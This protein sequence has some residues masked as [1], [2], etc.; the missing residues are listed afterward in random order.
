MKKRYYKDIDRSTF[1]FIYGDSPIELLD[2]TSCYDIESFEYFL[3][4][5]MRNVSKR[6]I[7]SVKVRID[8]YDGLSILPYKKIDYTYKVKKRRKGED[9]DVIGATDYVPLPQSYYKTLEVT[10]V[11]VTFEGGET[12]VLG[13]SSA[14][15]A[16]L[17]ADQPNH[18][19][20]ACEIVDDSES[21][22][23]KY[24]AVIFPQFGSSA[25]ICCCSQKN[26][27]D[28]EECE[29][30]TRSRDALKQIYTGENLEKVA[31][32]EAHGT[33][34]MTL[35]RVKGE[36]MDRREPKTVD[37]KKEE[38][39]EE[40]K[41][42]VEARERYKEKMRIQALPRFALYFV[43]AYLLYFILNWIFGLVPQ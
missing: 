16:K 17:I 1:D 12:M 21:I 20:A 10:V 27:A 31:Y 2:R 26:K 43:L 14:K 7:T 30:C 11:S 9:P 34:T 36:F 35:R 5:R 40:Q 15:K 33:S 19:I 22:R 39:I 18:I 6:R 32:D 37:T 23:D 42:K 24:P 3:V 28:S 29:R 25:W 4:V 8:L 41:K 13:L 38:Q